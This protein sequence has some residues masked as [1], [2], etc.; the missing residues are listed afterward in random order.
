MLTNQCKYLGYEYLNPINDFPK[1]MPYSATYIF[2]FFTNIKSNR[3]FL[4]L[5]VNNN[6]L[7]QI[8]C[9]PAPTCPDKKLEYI[10]IGCLIL[11]IIVIVVISQI[12]GGGA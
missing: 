12:G 2:Y 9:P 4:S 10:V 8:T 11:V 3:F 1:K 5:L 7:S 6:E